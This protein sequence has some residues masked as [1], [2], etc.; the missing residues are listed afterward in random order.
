[1]GNLDT[2]INMKRQGIPEQEIINQLSQQG[3]SPFEIS[4]ALKQAEIKNAVSGYSDEE[5]DDMQP[6]IMPR[7]EAPA[8]SPR[9]VPQ[10]EAYQPQEYAQE[11]YAP[12]TQEQQYYAPETGAGYSEYAQQGMNTDTMMEIADQVFSEKMKKPQKI[13]EATSEA[14]IL[15]Q[16]KFENL[17]ER[18]KKIETLIDKL[19]IAILE[20]VGSYGTTLGEVKKEMSMMQ[21]SFSKVISSPRHKSEEKEETH[22]KISKK[23]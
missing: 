20:K 19:Q 12:A 9:G 3:V 4:N 22:K 13:I 1:M 11:S 21:D 7:G 5:G 16:N 23:K 6:S 8:Q 10:E 18:L 2:V 14:A 17:S 15:L